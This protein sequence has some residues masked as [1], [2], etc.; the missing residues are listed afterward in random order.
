MNRIET[1]GLFSLFFY[2]A[3]GFILAVISW[4]AIKHYA[5]SHDPILA[6]ALMGM[7][8][9]I[10]GNFF[11]DRWRPELGDKHFH[12]SKPWKM[13]YLTT[14]NGLWWRVGF[15]TIACLIVHA[16]LA[17]LLLLTTT[18]EPEFMVLLGS[19]FIV[20]IPHLYWSMRG[21]YEPVENIDGTGVTRHELQYRGGSGLDRRT[22][23]LF[24]TLMSFAGVVLAFVGV[25][26][27]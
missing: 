13:P 24:P 23:W 14:S 11:V 15:K 4:S 2:V 20:R 26:L 3:A 17:T 16:I 27:Y 7:M 21:R 6:I 22:F 8:F 9:F 18:A 5:V 25:L 1:S 12:P 19:F 10:V